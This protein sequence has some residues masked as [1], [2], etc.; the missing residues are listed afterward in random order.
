MTPVLPTHLFATVGGEASGSTDSVHVSPR[1]LDMD[2][3][4]PVLRYPAGVWRDVNINTIAEGAIPTPR[5][6]KRRILDEIVT[7][8]AKSGKSS[9]STVSTPR[10]RQPKRNAAPTSLEDVTEV[11][12]TASDDVQ[13]SEGGEQ[14]IPRLYEIPSPSKRIIKKKTIVARKHTNTASSLKWVVSI[15]RCLHVIT[16]TG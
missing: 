5:P 8:P 4:D 10:K 3:Q 7:S 13:V 11:E 12:S 15:P 9:S 14:P 16:E 1:Y 6:D 2:V